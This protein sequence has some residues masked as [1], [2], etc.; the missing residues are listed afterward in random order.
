MGTNKIKTYVRNFDEALDGGIPENHV[1]LITGPSGAM[2][3]SL[4]YY[5][6]YNNAK[7]GLNGLYVSLEQDRG[8][9]L[10]D[11][12]VL[13][14][15]VNAVSDKL[16]VFDA[17]NRASLEEKAAELKALGLEGEAELDKGTFMPTFRYTVKWI[18]ERLGIN[19]V[20]VDSLDSLEVLSGLEDVRSELFS[21]FEWLRELKVTTILVAESVPPLSFLMQP[22]LGH[23]E[24]FL[25][26]GIIQLSME[27]TDAVNFQRRIRCV[28][29]RSANHSTDHFTLIY[30][31]GQFEVTKAIY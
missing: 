4:A 5:M 27:K 18:K 3:S 16:H 10:E 2:K 13:G 31:H 25:A 15:N 14:L 22:Q 24:D 9:F 19:L 21:F 17:G 7:K 6:L 29:M 26:D 1:V 20:V 30:E 12:S 28:K 11:I 8:D 23:D